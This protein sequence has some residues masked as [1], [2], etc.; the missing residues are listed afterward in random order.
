[1]RLMLVVSMAVSSMVSQASAVQSAK[2]GA[3][4]VLTRDLLIAHSPASKESLNITLKVPPQEEKAGSGSGCQ[5]GD[6]MLQ[7]DAFAADTFDRTFGKWTPVAGVGQKA[8]F[9][10]N[11]GRWAELAAVAGGRVITIQMDVPT[12][13][14]AA[15]IQPN[16]VSLAKAILAKLK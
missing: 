9:R 3:C 10:D 1:M 15:S 7:I 11:G 12:G 14:T 16:T 5:Y 4:S 8:Y 13:R 6:V 2:P